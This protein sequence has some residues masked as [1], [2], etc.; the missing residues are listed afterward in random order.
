MSWRT[1]EQTKHQC[2]S[3]FDR[4]LNKSLIPVVIYDIL[5]GELQLCVYRQYFSVIRQNCNMCI[6]EISAHIEVRISLLTT[7]GLLISE[8]FNQVTRR[9]VGQ[10]VTCVL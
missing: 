1:G 10:E 2:K 7:T 8:E 5:Q 9:I 4:L 3:L 6:F